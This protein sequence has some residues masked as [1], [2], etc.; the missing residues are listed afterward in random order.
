MSKTITKKSKRLI[1]ALLKKKENDAKPNKTKVRTS[2]TKP[3][4]N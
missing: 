3:Q 2:S 1:D 4:T